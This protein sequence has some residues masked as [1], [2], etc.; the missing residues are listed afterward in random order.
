MPATGSASDI[1]ISGSTS[2]GSSTPIQACP[3]CGWPGRR[4]SWRNAWGSS[5][6]TCSS[7]PVGSP[8]TE[9]SDHLLD[10]DVG[11]STHFDHVETE[12]S[13]RTRILDYLWTGLPIVATTVS[14]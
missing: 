12:F 3:T 9:R 13:F 7:I 2:W 10:A 5:D 8:Y 11:V 6:G 14:Y 4:S 1:P